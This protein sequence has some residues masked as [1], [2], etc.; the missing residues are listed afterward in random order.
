MPFDQELPKRGCLWLKDLP[1]EE[2]Y[3]ALF[4][5]HE[6]LDFPE[7]NNPD[8]YRKRH[9]GDFDSMTCVFWATASGSYCLQEDSEDYFPR[10]ASDIDTLIVKWL[11]QPTRVVDFNAL[12]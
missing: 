9:D 1:E 6:L 12:S 7:P 10:R 3:K 11:T 8:T 5:I 2:K 4:G